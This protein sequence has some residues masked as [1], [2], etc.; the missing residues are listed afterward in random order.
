MP[1][2][3]VLRDVLKLL[4]TRGLPC[5]KGLCFQAIMPFTV[6]AKGRIDARRR[7]RGEERVEM[8]SRH[9][10][11]ALER[12]SRPSATPGQAP[13]LPNSK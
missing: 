4:I 9:E 7:S 12:V 8:H 5:L 3:L 1:P 13:K 11:S 2:G 6:E 10:D